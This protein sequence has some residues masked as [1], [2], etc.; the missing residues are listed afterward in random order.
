MGPLKKLIFIDAQ[1]RADTR[2]L[3]RARLEQLLEPDRLRLHPPPGRGAGPIHFRSNWKSIFRGR[4]TGALFSSGE[5]ALR[6]RWYCHP[7]GLRAQLGRSFVDRPRGE[8]PS[9][10]GGI[11][12]RRDSAPKR[13]PER[14]GPSTARCSCSNEG[15]GGARGERGPPP[16]PFVL[17]RHPSSSFSS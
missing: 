2:R 1:P 11:A 15:G 14:S 16:P 10:R 9:G 12:A 4:G 7:P 17:P 6:P 8:A 3:R 13:G 5:S